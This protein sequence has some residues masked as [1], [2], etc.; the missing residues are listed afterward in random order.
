MNGPMVTTSRICK[1]QFLHVTKIGDD[2]TMQVM[3]GNAPRV[4]VELAKS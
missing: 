4:D 1:S 2:L 3:T